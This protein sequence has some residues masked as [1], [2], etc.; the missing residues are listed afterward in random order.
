MEKT[1]RTKQALLMSALSL[2]LCIS[3]FVGT[4]FAWFTDKV[5]SG[6]NIIK[7]GKLNVEMYWADGTED[8]ANTAWKDASQG[9]IFNYELWEPGYVSVRHIKI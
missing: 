7:S 6:S 2:L 3:L 9:S 5:S 8:P 1:K 4:T